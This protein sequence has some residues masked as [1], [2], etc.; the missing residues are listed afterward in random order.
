[1]KVLQKIYTV[2][3]KFDRIRIAV[4]SER[5]LQQETII[6]VIFSNQYERSFHCVNILSTPKLLHY[7]L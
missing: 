4:F 3:D 7:F 6:R 1:M 5:C 2:L